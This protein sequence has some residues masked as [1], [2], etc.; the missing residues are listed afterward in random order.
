MPIQKERAEPAR[1][2]SKTA[3]AVTQGNNR[4]QYSILRRSAIDIEIG[5]RMD[6]GEERNSR[7]RK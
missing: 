2:S 6:R 4:I 3:D 7:I 1:S 5:C